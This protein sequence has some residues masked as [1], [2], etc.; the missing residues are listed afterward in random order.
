[1]TEQKPNKSAN[2]WIATD[3]HF[4][5]DHRLAPYILVPKGKRPL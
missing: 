1:M 5:T 3:H 2:A 4:G